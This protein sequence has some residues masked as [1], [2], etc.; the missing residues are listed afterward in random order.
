MV[1]NIKTNLQISLSSRWGDFSKMD[2]PI[3]LI[4]I[5]YWQR[6]N[7]K[8]SFPLLYS[9]RTDFFSILFYF[10]M[11]VINLISNML[12]VMP[13]IIFFFLAKQ[14]SLLFIRE[15]LIKAD[16]ETNRSCKILKPQPPL[17]HYVSDQYL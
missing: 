5:Q 15:I 16:C 13:D 7:R 9:Q 4:L 14:Q 17:P 11:Y 3:F 1:L 12:H 2:I 8:I 10:R 6:K